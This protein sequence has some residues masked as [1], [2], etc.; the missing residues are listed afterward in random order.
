MA[1]VFHPRSDSIRKKCFLTK[2]ALKGSYSS[3]LPGIT[4]T[5]LGERGSE[6]IQHLSEEQGTAV[7]DSTG[8]KENFP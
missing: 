4:L 7:S 6:V 2:G 1:S 3:S 8:G 5:L